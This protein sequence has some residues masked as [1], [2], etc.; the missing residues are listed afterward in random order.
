[1][2]RSVSLALG[3]VIVSLLSLNGQAQQ[4]L[5]LPP[6]S[7]DERKEVASATALGAPANGVYPPG[8]ALL[9]EPEPTTP[10]GNSPTYFSA[11]TPS[12]PLTPI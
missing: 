2:M 7:Q 1:M 5:Q 9:A 8:T 3:C 6:S 10:T 12:A 11:R 4:G